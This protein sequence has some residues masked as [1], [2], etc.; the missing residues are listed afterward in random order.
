[1]LA[2][3]IENKQIWIKARGFEFVTSFDTSKSAPD[4]KVFVVDKITHLF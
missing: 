2:S 4:K 3:D 1:M